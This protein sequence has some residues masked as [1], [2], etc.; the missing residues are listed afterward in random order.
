MTSGPRAASS[1]QPSAT[2]ADATSEAKPAKP[3]AKRDAVATR[4][5]ILAVATREFAA[6][7]FEGATTDDVASRARINKRMIYHYFQNKDRL[8]LEVLEAAYA[9]ARAAEEGLK[10]EGMDPLAALTR[11]TE[12]TFDSFARDSTFISLLSTE[13]RQKAKALRKSRKVGEINSTILR[14]VDRILRE[15]EAGGQ[16]RPGLDA[17]QLW[18]SVVGLSYFYFSNMHTLSVIVGQSLSGDAMLADRRK[19]V[20]DFVQHA[21]RAA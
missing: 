11:L 18:I 15:G 13:N 10:L 14:A 2:P 1:T 19:H 7:G 12:F 17:L 5:R 8:Y 16:F 9:K 4:A 3:R 20:V 21:V 6:K